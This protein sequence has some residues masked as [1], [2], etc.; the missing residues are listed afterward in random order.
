MTT[1]HFVTRGK[2]ATLAE[3]MR[4]AEARAALKLARRQLGPR[5]LVRHEPGA[6]EPCVVFRAEQVI[7]GRRYEREYGRGRTWPIA[8]QRAAE[9]YRAMCAEARARRATS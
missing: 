1:T 5:A 6:D 4:N 3:V 7:S 8:L 9:G 2:G